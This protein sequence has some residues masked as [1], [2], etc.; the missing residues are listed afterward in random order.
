MLTKIKPYIIAIAITL[1]TGTLAAFITRNNMQ[2]YD[3]INTPPL[4]PPAILFP[5]VWTILYILMGISAAMIYNSDVD[6]QSKKKAL[7]TFAIS[8]VFNFLWS[9]IFFNFQLYLVAF[10]CL[11]LL[12]IWIVKTFIEYKQLNPIAA[13]LQIPYIIWVAFAGYLN[14]A[15]FLLN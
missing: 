6:A 11:V 12:F 5:I 9:I 13:Y 4:A 10:I 14:F 1:G 15:I 8:L 7:T 3:K 2:I